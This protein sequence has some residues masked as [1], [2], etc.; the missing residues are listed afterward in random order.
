M[1]EP[2]LRDCAPVFNNPDP[3]PQA[4]DAITLVALALMGALLVVLMA[5]VQ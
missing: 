4:S 3:D 1:A 5:I 2:Y